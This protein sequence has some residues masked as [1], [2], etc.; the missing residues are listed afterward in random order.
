MKL[1][2]DPRPALLHRLKDLH[3]WLIC[4]ITSL[5][6]TEGLISLNITLVKNVIPS[7]K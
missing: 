6:N 2:N 4:I 1:N 5:W 3:P 7:S